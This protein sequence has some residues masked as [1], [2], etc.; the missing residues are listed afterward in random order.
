MPTKNLTINV[1]LDT[2]TRRAVYKVNSDFEVSEAI[3]SLLSVMIKLMAA[4][5]Q[6]KIGKMEFKPRDINDEI[7]KR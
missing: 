4:R 2:N 6:G 7:G 5:P 3:Y 1:E